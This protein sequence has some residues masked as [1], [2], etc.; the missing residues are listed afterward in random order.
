MKLPRVLIIILNIYALVLA[1]ILIWPV[2]Q[3]VLTSFTSDVVFPPRHFS[4][5][6]FQE[7]IWSSFFKAL[8]YSLKLAFWATVLLIAICLPAAYAMERRRFAGR[9]LMS[10]LI[11]VPTI[12]PSVTYVSAIGVYVFM[13]FTDLRGTFPII[14]VATAMSAIPLV[15]RSIQGS[16]ATTDPM[17]EEAAL[18][19]GAAPL[20]AFV[21]VTLPLIAPGLI[22]AMM[23]AFTAASTAFI[24]PQLLGARERTVSMFI[25]EDIGKLGFT[26]WIAVE[27]LAMEAVVLG[28]VQT[29]YFVFRKQFR[30]LF[31]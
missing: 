15:V 10:V 28:A 12:F 9:G 27:V 5:D 4:F 17:Y 20:Q 14:V 7:V 29:L 6:A 11:F 8:R 16:L 2:L 31:V 18:V 21:K 26:T 19:M 24:A 23:I 22:T 1:F 30:G 3:M 13:F 25:Y